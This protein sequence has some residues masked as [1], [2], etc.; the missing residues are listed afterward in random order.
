MNVAHRPN[1]RA[2]AAPER[3]RRRQSDVAPLLVHIGYHKAG[4][5]WLQQDLLNDPAAGFTTETGERRQEVIMRIAVPDPLS[6]DPQN[7]AAHYGP[8]LSLAREKGVTLA[9]SHERLSGHPSSGGR[10]R[11]MI[12]DRLKA[13]FP[14]ARILI[15]F[16]EQRALIQSMYSQHISAGGVE[17][18]RRYL[19]T[20]EPGSVRR[21][22]FAFEFYE[23]D[24]LIDYYRRLFGADRVLA[25]PLELLGA[26]PSEFAS[27]IAE[28]CG[29]PP[30]ERSNST[31]RNVRRPQLMQLVQRPL[32]MLFF[33]NDLS[34]GAL[35]H[36]HRFHLRFK[37]WRPFFDV[38][39][40]K[41][42]DDWILDRQRRTVR[43]VVGER[44]AKSNRR[45]Q[46][47]TGISLGELGYPVGE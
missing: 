5:T 21:P 38:I 26:R 41:F 22:S 9:L 47:L 39:S 46:D 45:T 31:V 16:R 36:I 1:G 4:S 8:S 30:L 24:T 11:C 13:T 20:P 2:G 7:V 6:Y 15:V 43:E 37:Q 28:F 14:D 23:F 34:P 25:L 3:S 42:L 18:L 44:Y 27:R 19:A 12:A 40:P 32:N 33:H 35:F 10:D 17:S 29:H